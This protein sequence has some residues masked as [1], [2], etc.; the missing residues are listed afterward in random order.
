MAPGA[1]DV[2]PGRVLVAEDEEHLGTLLAQ[3]L[4]GRGLDVT[5]VRDGAAAV[6][7]LAGG[8]FDAAVVDVQMPGADGFAVL[9]AV[10][11][12]ARPAEVIIASGNGTRETALAALRGGAY[13]TVAK[14]YRMAEVEL[15]VR[16]A[17]EVRRLR[18]TVLRLQRE[19]E[20]LRAEVERR[21]PAPPSAAR[22][23]TNDA[24]DAPA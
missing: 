23:G 15:V 9:T 19:C 6:A 14:P 2:A 12:L 4:R 17:V 8:K 5:L 18:D 16:R 20:T 13:A 3:F 11:G 22:G 7:E 21:G 1:E 24:G 10:A